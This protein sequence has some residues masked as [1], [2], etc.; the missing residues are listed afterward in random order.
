MSRDV[1]MERI[2][3]ARENLVVKHGGVENYINYVIQQDA[4]RRKKM[5][6]TR[7][8]KA[9]SKTGKVKVQRSA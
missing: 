1:L 4:A 6:T 2:W 5:K 3:K 7:I 8:K 9:V